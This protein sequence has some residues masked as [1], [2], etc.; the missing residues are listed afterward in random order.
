MGAEYA[1]VAG[2]IGAGISSYGAWQEGQDAKK[3]AEYNASVARQES[4][5]IEQSGALDASR[6]R[7]Q[8]SKLVGRQKAAYGA[9]GVELT[10]SVI[11]TMMDTAAEGEYDA[12]VIEYNT[13]VRSI[14]ALSQAEYQDRLAG[15]YERSGIIKAGTT[16][17]TQGA[18]IG[19]NYYGY[20]F[21]KKQQESNN[22]K[23]GY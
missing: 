16:L 8:V 18:N 10:G 14:G 11:D 12:K 2:L 6:Q 9:S 22:Q 13:K 20:Q 17:L 23:G 21:K 15:I 4:Q 5:M 3:A 7:K 19:T 1:L